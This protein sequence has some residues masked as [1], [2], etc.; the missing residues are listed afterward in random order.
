MFY[1][2]YIRLC[3]RAGKSPSAVAQAV[4]LQKSTV[5]RWKRGALPTDATRFKIADYFGVPPDDLLRAPQDRPPL[6]PDGA[7]GSLDELRARFGM[8]VPD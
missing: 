7:G 3:N 5:T 8:R 1:E 4:G 6:L 2:N